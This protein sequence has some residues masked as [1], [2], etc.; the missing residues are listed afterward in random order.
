MRIL[1]I[2]YF[3]RMKKDEKGNIYMS[4]HVRGPSMKSFHKTLL[5]GITA[6]RYTSCGNTDKL[7]YQDFF[8]N[9]KEE[10]KTR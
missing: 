4:E 7:I 10:N 3:T 2:R 5:A 6:L 1:H 9:K 8:V